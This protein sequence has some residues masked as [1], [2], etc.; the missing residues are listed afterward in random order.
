HAAEVFLGKVD[1]LDA[2]FFPCE[3]VHKFWATGCRVPL[4]IGSHKDSNTEA[5]GELRTYARLDPGERFSYPGWIEAVRAGRTFASSGV[6]LF[7]SADGRQPGETLH[8]ADANQ[9]VAV[10]ADARSILP[11]D[12]VSLYFN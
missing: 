4:A 5:V 11:F 7:L 8:L 9:S 6:L 10:R 3:D 12:G 1:A 2:L